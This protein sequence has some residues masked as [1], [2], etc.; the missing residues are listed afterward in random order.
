MM[1]AGA[2]TRADVFLVRNGYAATRAEAQSAIRAGF[3]R[4]DGRVVAKVSEQLDGSAA[5]DYEKAHPYVSRGAL[6]LI[7]AL[8]RFA[9]SPEGS[10]CLDIG[11]STGG[12]TQVL[13]ER[14]AT[15]VYAV[16]VGHN[17]FAG[18][19]ARDPRVALREGINAREL[20]E[21]DVPEQP[22]AIVADVSFISLK[23]ALPSALELA[24]QGAWLVALIK[25]QF[26][27]GREKIGKGGIVRDAAARESAV[28]DFVRWI[29]TTSGWSVIGRMESPIVGGDGNVEF[30]VAARKS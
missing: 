17:Q 26:E 1:P 13:L 22:S 18:D 29:S 4:A 9:L 12:F 7:A 6:K 20:S 8:D 30:L 21:K 23:L 14:G 16:D 15:K 11:A 5:I 3:V 27:V 24:A 28:E 10:V 25:P 2:K 19:L